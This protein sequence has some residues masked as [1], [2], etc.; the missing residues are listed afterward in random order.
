MKPRQYCDVFTE[1]KKIPY[2]TCVSLRRY[3]NRFQFKGPLDRRNV[4]NVTIN[5]SYSVMENRSVSFYMVHAYKIRNPDNASLITHYLGFWNPGSHTLKLPVS[6]K[7]R[8]DFNRLPIIFGVLNGTNDV[9]TDIVEAGANDIAPLVD[10]ATFVTSSV[11][12]R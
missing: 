7:L 5:L 12:A 8:N 4:E 2:R 1:K 10:F 11:N 9:H 6:V 3:G